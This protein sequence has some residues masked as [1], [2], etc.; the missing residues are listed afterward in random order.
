MGGAGQRKLGHVREEGGLGGKET[1]ARKKRGEKLFQIYV[2]DTSYCTVRYFT[3]CA[4]WRG[5]GKNE[6]VRVSLS[7]WKKRGGDLHEGEQ[8]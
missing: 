5:K 2:F 3:S 1:G 4:G 6:V 8:R 7:T